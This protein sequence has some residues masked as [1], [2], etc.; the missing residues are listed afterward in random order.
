VAIRAGDEQIHREP[1]PWAV[2][3]ARRRPN[4]WVCKSAGDNVPDGIV[5]PERIRV[6]VE[7]MRPARSSAISSPTRISWL[8]GHDLVLATWLE[9]Q[10]TQVRAAAG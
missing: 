2:K 4:G 1:S 10:V 5:P 9:R 3:E 8:D 6:R 7:Q